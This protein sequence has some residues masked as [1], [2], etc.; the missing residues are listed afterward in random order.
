MSPETHRVVE[1]VE[2]RRRES[3]ETK[4]RFS[5]ELEEAVAQ[6]GL[7]VREALE[8]GHRVFACGNGGSAADAQHFVAELMGRY[9]RERDPMPAMA[10][11]T[12]TSS[13]TAIGNDYGYEIVFARQLRG[14][15]KAGDVLVGITT[16]GSSA[17][18][19]E[20]AR[21]AHELGGSV[22]GLTGEDGRELATLSDICLRVPS[23]ETPRIQE[24]HIL[25]LH[26]IAEIA[27]LEELG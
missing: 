9:L 10:L 16:S 18:I 13:L 8:S 19:L 1:L 21:V 7:L 20:A 3:C 11:T 4:E 22:I 17:N 5:R 25:I 24:S 26:T 23:S 27:E 14:W 12:N 6:A 15:M 2:R